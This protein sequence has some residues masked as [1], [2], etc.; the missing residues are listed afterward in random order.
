MIIHYKNI[1]KVIGMH[2]DIFKEH[3]EKVFNGECH[4]WKVPTNQDRIP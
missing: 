4:G 2:L 1:I 3:K